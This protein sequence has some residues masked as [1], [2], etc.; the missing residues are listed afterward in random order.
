M[1]T[2]RL[3][4][5]PAPISTLHIALFENVRNAP[6][7]R[8]RL[9]TAATTEGA[10]GD[11]LRAE[12][13]FGFVEADL[14]VSKQHLLTAIQT[15]LLCT[16]PAVRTSPTEPTWST[17]KT[18]SHNVHSELLLFLS[19]NNNISDSIRRHG[20]SD[21]TTR[22]AVVRI[23][24]GAESEAAVFEAMRAVVQGELVGLD[25]LDDGP[26]D[27]ARVDKIYKLG[28]MNSLKVADVAAAKRAAVI[29]TVAI[30]SV[31]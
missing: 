13:D 11:R 15:T 28:E 24:D 20:L 14:L 12:V 29:N 30:K 5:F 7:I 27:W 8:R 16:L 2:Y 26:K 3:S 19:P 17:L 22:L 18:R 21:A 23:G 9:V 31:V 1:E 10:E 25:R 4:H 6:E